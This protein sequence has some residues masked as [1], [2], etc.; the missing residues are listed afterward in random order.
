[1]DTNDSYMNFPGM[2]MQ[3]ITMLQQATAGL[4]GSQKEYFMHVYS[5][6]R[7]NPEDVR[8]YCIASIAIPGLHRFM[9]GQTG[10]AVLYFFTGGLF[11]V[12]TIMVEILMNQT[13]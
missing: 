12:M 5:G 13:T 8:L 3:E 2:T 7:K 4:D 11:F 10:W 9:L 6:K 1:M